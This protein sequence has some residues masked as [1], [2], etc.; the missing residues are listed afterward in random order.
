MGLTGL[1][2]LGSL[3]SAAAPPALAVNTDGL[4]LY[5]DAAAQVQ[6]GGTGPDNNVWRNLAE[7]PD[8]VAG[9]GELRHFRFDTTSG[10]VGSGVAGDPVALRFDG[11]SSYVVGPGN[12]ELPELT[13]EAWAMVEGTAGQP[14]ARGATLIGN[15]FGLGGIS[16][17]IQPAT[18]APLLLHGVTFTPVAADTPAREWQQVAVTLQG[19]TARLYVNGVFQ[20]ALPAPRDLQPDH[21]PSYQLGAARRP[22][23]DTVEADGLI[24]CLAIV[25]AYSRALSAAEVRANFEA[26]RARFGLLP[27]G[28]IAEPIR[29]VPAPEVPG[30]GPAPAACCAKWDYWEH[31]VRVTGDG[32]PGWPYGPRWAFD[33]YPTNL[34]R[35]YVRNYWRT[36][37]PTPEHPV[38][39]TVDYRR[40][41]A[42]TRFT[43]YFDR[44][45][46]PCAWR[47]VDVLVSDDQEQW[48]VVQRF[49]DLPPE[50]PQGLGLDHPR[51]ARFYRLIIR[52]LA[53]GAPAIAT[54]EIETVYGATIGNAEASP[55][56]PVQSEP[57]RLRVRVVSPD[58]PL[59][60]GTLR[61]VAPKGTMQGATDVAVPTGGGLATLALTPLQ[62]GPTP[63]RL[64]LHVG[65]QL[66]DQRTYTIRAVPKLAL[67]ELNPAGAVV[68][69]AGNSVQVTG[70]VRNDG[71]TRAQDVRLSWL[72]KVAAL[73]DLAPKESARFTLATNAR[74]GYHE[75]LL[76]VDAAGGAH[77]VL[78]RAVICEQ[79]SDHR[80][81][82]EWQPDA[83]AA[84]FSLKTEGMAAPVTGQLSA[85]AAGQP[86]AL[87][88]VGPGPAGPVL[89]AAVPG[90]VL[91]VEVRR[92]KGDAGDPELRCRVVPD[93]P[94]PLVPPFLDLE[95]RVAVDDPQIMFRPH[96]DWYRVAE[97]PHV[98]QTANGHHSATRMLCVQTGAGTVSLVP[99]TDNMTW[100]FTPDNAMT[101]SFQVPLAPHDPLGQGIWRPIYEAPTEFTLTLP[102]RPGTWW[103]A[104]RHVTTDLF[105]FEEARQ[106]AMPITQLQMLSARYVMRYDVWSEPWQTVRSH[107]WV[108]FFYNFYG[109]T[110]T[111]PALYSWYL[112]TDDETARVKAAKVADWLLSVQEREGPLAGAWFSQYCV[113]GDP[114]RLV[115]RDQ[116]WN[117]W[118]MPHAGGSAAKTLLWY[119][120]AGGRRDG[121]VLVAA[122]RCCDWLLATQRPDG[123]WPY[124]FDLEG[125]PVTDLP[126]AGQI[127][128][129]WA[130][131]QMD[132]A[133]GDE[134][135]RQAAERSKGFFQQAFMARHR[136]EGYWED[137]SGA[138]G[139]VARS[140]E[141]YEPAI[142][143]CAF[144]DMGDRDLAVEAAQDAATWTW[145]RVI[146]TRQYETCYGETT[147]QS[148]CGPSQA[149]SP[150]IGIGLQRVREVT[151]DPLWGAFA[152][153]MKAINF[154]ADPDQAY[155]MVATGGWD[156]PTTGVVGP[157][158]DNVR[159]FV[160][161]NNSRGDEYGRQVWNEWETS[162]FA[163]LALEWLVREGNRR[164]PQHVAINPY[165]LRG[166]VLG[167]P[168]RVKMPEERCDV[169][170]FEHHDLNWVG[171]QNDSQYVLLVMNHKEPLRVAIRP[172]EAHLGVYCRPP[173]VLVSGPRAY[174]AV[175]AEKQGEQTVVGI[176]AEGTALVVW[177]RI[178]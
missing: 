71:A 170:G 172:H 46:T 94:N 76:V 63:V 20:A 120:E 163:W 125:R 6:A 65:E 38:A 144:A 69:A 136:Y 22:N 59:E 75:G 96:I 126:D 165:T 45:R 138:G 140:W 143:A 40:P 168:G 145:T 15:D 44:F 147:E 37:P 174:E 64:E 47:R 72:G 108:D 33:G 52:E 117:R 73:G 12:L 93:D 83:G 148:F 124:A 87:V 14:T 53:A 17:I 139:K 155:G 25:R 99:D 43:H 80:R 95:L 13:L 90:G 177:D 92:R 24:G 70:T 67:A 21:Y 35:P 130:L 173:K 49:G 160:T 134:R 122:R 42:V 161:P 127:W 123:G 16:L 29:A 19:G 154:C 86:C 79:A 11:H 91:V 57:F 132:A 146:S 178:R 60:G 137:V 103:D 9:S 113:E 98:P 61:L 142:A 157:P 89:A 166:T 107:P 110:Y 175:P 176:P 26:D 101:I 119:W 1:F 121:R 77:S 27:G 109:T 106:W 8:S 4:I 58:A 62:A 112:A 116:A 28:A 153:A 88:P 51:P 74:P 32:T 104:Y 7:Q 81:A 115:G 102:V 100:G 68:A 36:D 151:G 129:T 133:T 158:Y 135:Y 84:R 78:R 10:W 66:I 114:P 18:G 169:A 54:H 55:A 118:V 5:L 2:S 162:Q 164:A 31:P 152:G 171:Y 82:S 156:D 167:V 41:V 50:A 48:E 141:G 3:L 128:C 131:W 30:L 39:V 105:G 159:P 97:G 23:N 149:Q 85:L 34:S 56:T 111:L 150:M